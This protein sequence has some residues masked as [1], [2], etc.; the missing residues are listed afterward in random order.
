[1]EDKLLAFI[2]DIAKTEV[3]RDTRLF[4]DRVLDSMNILDLIGFIEKQL[5]RRLHEDE[6]TMRHF[7][8]PATILSTFFS[9]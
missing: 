2:S 5:K 4:S 3:T 1:M 9:S 6:I 8:T 7:E